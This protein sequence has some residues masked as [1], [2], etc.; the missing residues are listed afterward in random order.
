M[1]AKNILNITTRAEFRQW[2]IENHRKETECWM[3]AKK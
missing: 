1:E 2:L 3:V